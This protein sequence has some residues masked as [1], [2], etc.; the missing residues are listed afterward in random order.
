MSAFEGLTFETPSGTTKMALGK[1]HQGIQGTAYGMSKSV[2]GKLTITNVKRYAAEEV[3]PPEG[4]K[5]E[6]WIRSGSSGGETDRCGHAGGNHCVAPFE[7]C[8][9]MT[10]S[11]TR[12]EGTTSV[13]RASAA[14]RAARCAA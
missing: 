2:Q 10:P 6:D 9:R 3:N 12:G 7:G 4:V 11:P 13:V 1:G 5:S 8:A 14:S